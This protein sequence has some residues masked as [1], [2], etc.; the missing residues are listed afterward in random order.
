MKERKGA[1]SIK[2]IPKDILNSLNRGELE[3]VN[4]IEWLAV[5]QKI[6]LEH[7]LTENNRKEYYSPLVET[8]NRLKKQTVNTVNEAI[9]TG[10]LEL[11][12]KYNDQEIKSLMLKHPADLVRCWSAYII[13]RNDHLTIE[14]IVEQIKELAADKHFGVREISWMAVRPAIA[15]DL[16]KSL[17]ILTNWTKSTDDTIRRFASES[18]RPRGVWCSHIEALKQNPELG[19]TILEPLRSDP[20]KYVRDSVGNWLND[21]SKSQPLLVKNIC[22][23]WIS[24]SPVKETEYIVKRALRTIEKK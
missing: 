21:A 14:E 13:G 1:R 17:L 24:E 3:T 4:L 19:L 22:E 7:L 9:G 8:I 5:D 15:K 6:L 16:S 2:D 18:T 20:S 23:R 11:S 12:A 10:I